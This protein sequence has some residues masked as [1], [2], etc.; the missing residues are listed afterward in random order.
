MSVQIFELLDG[1]VRVWIEQ[2]AV[3]IVAGDSLHQDPTELTSEMARDLAIE[4]Q[5]LADVLDG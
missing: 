4:L 5:R 1:E 2:E 3:H